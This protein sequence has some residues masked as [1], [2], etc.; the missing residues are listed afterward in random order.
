MPLFSDYTKALILQKK[1]LNNSNNASVETKVFAK[2]LSKEFIQSKLVEYLPN[3]NLTFQSFFQ[4][5]IPKFV[6][7]NKI[8]TLFLTGT[9]PFLSFLNKI[10]SNKTPSPLCG[11]E[12]T[13]IHLLIS[14][15]LTISITHKYF[16][17]INSKLFTKNK[18]NFK[19]FNLICKEMYENFLQHRI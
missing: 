2:T 9:G 6:L 13:S 3:C 7:P 19:K 18:T 17:N 1:F 16:E 15:P 10:G 11:E 4:H 14:C 12:E 5:S 8:N